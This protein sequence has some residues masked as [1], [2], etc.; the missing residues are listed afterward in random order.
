MGYGGHVWACGCAPEGSHDKR[1]EAL[2]CALG[3]ALLGL[4]YDGCVLLGAFNDSSLYQCNETQSFCVFSK[5]KNNAGM[6]NT[7]I[8]KYTIT[9]CHDIL[10]PT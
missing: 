5:R 6:V 1:L 8:E 2:C 4:L 3:V 7:G 10:N 9:K